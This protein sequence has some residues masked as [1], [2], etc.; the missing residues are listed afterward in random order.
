M[1]PLANLLA[2][3]WV[4]LGVVPPALAGAGAGAVVARGRAAGAR[5][6][7]RRAAPGVGR[8]RVAGGAAVRAVAAGRAAGVGRGAGA[9]RRRRAAGPG[10]GCR[11]ARRVPWRWRRCSP[12]APARPPAGAVWLDVLDVGQGLAAVVRTAEHTLVY[13]TGDRFSARFNAGSAV[14]VPFLRHAGTRALDA[15]VVSHGD[16]DHAGGTAAVRRAFP[17]ARLWAGE[18]RALGRDARLC[19]AGTAWRWDGVDF[20]FLHPD[21]DAGLLGND[22]SCV[23]R[24]DAPGGRIL[25]PGDIERAGERRLLA[26]GAALAADVVV[27][28]H[29]GS[30]TSSTPAFVA[31][32][33]PRWVIYAVG[34]GNRWGFPDPA[35]M[36]RWRPAGFARTD[37]AGALHLRI[38][39]GSGVRPP[40][41]WR[42]QRR[43]FWHA[44]CGA[45][46]KSG[47]MRAVSRRPAAA[48][49]GG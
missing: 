30:A 6:G 19:R 36:A 11:D 39:P 21:P 40:R 14:V 8:A 4:S 2:V 17:P 33:A 27:A 46:G 49:S 16:S 5:R 44:G 3:P 15:L 47:N 34:H 22:A 10:A 13:D 48:G 35:I 9:G 31:R 29:H 28:P 25:L 41:P 42:E 37:C 20:R 26:R 45:D 32:V 12:A 7:G 38:E 1:A 24:I 18:P 43:R 23:L